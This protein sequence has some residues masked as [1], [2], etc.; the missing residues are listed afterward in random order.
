M[1]LFSTILFGL[2]S[3]IAFGTTNYLNDPLNWNGAGGS[4]F[5]A[6]YDSRNPGMGDKEGA[7]YDCTIC[8]TGATG[9]ASNVNAYGNAF[10]TAWQAL[11]AAN[12]VVWQTGIPDKY[13]VQAWQQI[14]SA[15]SDGDG[16]SNIAEITAGSNPG[17]STST[18]TNPNCTNSGTIVEPS[19][20]PGAVYNPNALNTSCSKT[21]LVGGIVGNGKNGKGGGGSSGDPL[22]ELQAI[23]LFLV[24]FFTFAWLKLRIKA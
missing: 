15:D 18:P 24:P 3:S 21:P 13:A 9:S 23:L 5:I 12:G 11:D 22:R 10:L 20:G 14:E 16:A 2:F 17:D 6:Y 7:C 19:T 8:H 1:S 4:G